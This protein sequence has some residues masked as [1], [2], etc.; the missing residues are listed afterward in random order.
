MTVTV[1]LSISVE[2]E[3]GERKAYIQARIMRTH[4]LLLAHGK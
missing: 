1:G 2:I 4:P 3:N